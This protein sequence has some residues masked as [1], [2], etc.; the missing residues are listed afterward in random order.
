MPSA[1]PFRRYLIGQSLSYVGDGLRLFTL[2]LLVFQMTGSAFS[3]A[4]AFLFGQLPFSLVS[5]VAGS[6]ADR[7]D[8]RRLMMAMDLAR[9]AVLAVTAALLA[10]KVLS[11]PAIYGATALLASAEALFEGAQTPSVRQMTGTEQAT[12]ALASLSTIAGTS[13][14]ATPALAGMLFSWFG[15]VPALIVDAATFLASRV[16]LAGLPQLGPDVPSSLPGAGVIARDVA[17]GFRR[18]F[19]DDGLAAQTSFS[20]VLSAIS[21]AQFTILIPFL[22]E[23]FGAAPAQIGLFLSLSAL[24]GTAGYLV[25]ARIRRARAVGALIAIAYVADAVMFLPIVY[26]RQIWLACACWALCN[27]FASYQVAQVIGLRVRVVP[28][29][30]LGRAIAAARLLASCLIPV[31]VVVLGWLSDRAGARQSMTAAAYVYLCAALVAA[32]HPA[33]RRETR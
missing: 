24:G 3:T 22:R 28:A 7:V 33:I 26:T 27:A 17:L 1:A 6:F 18:L 10:A 5:V 15:A 19:G 20:L 9:A 8:R 21:F 2:P 12:S 11:V 25:T 23:D 13:R 14:V 16:A 31:C 4:A 30:S 32:A 29:E